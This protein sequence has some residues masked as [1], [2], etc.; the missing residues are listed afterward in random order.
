MNNTNNTRQPNDTSNITDLFSGDDADGRIELPPLPAIGQRGEDVC[1]TIRLYL[2]IWNDL[3]PAQRNVVL[4]H[5]QI[6]PSCA[7]EQQVLGRATQIVQRMPHSEPSA[8]VD[9]AVLAAIAKRR[10]ASAASTQRQTD[11]ISPIAMR[12]TVAA[13]RRSSQRRGSTLRTL[14]LLAAVVVC[15]FAISLAIY[16]AIGPSQQAFA[17]PGN[18]SWNKYVLLSKQTMMSNQGVPYQVISYDN[19]QAG[20]VNVE[21]VMNGKLDVVV[22]GDQKEALGMDMM[23]HVAQWDAQKWMSDTSSFDLA[24][25]RQDLQDKKAVYT[26][27]ERFQGQDVYCIRYSDGHML[28]LNKDYM[29]VNVLEPDQ[30]QSQGKPMYETLQWLT[31]SKISSSMWNMQVPQGF[32]MGKLPAH[33]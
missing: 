10:Q 5:M 1:A 24:T 17:L 28:L 19:M 12:S 23:H 18:L 21:T 16:S 6:C 15:V 22:V 31:P 30:A 25:V 7:R 4:Q 20:M 29:P 11:A 8:R 2:G 9:Q 33:P 26:G 14:S 13:A 32:E 3:S 27:K